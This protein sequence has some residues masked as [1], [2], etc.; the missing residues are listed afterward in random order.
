MLWLS[1]GSGAWL[2]HWRRVATSNNV[3]YV[4]V[5]VYSGV[6]DGGQEFRKDE[7]FSVIKF[8]S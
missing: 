5:V 1:C 8:I 2:D 3:R 4:P 7:A 6:V